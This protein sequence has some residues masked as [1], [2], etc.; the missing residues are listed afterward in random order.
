MRTRVTAKRL[1]QKTQ[2]KRGEKMTEYLII[3]NGVAGTTAAENI[4]KND[5]DGNITI[6]TD[7]DCPF[8]YRV[9]LNDYIAGE[10]TESA[11]KAKK[12]Q[13]Y[14]DLKINL[15]LK[16]RAVNVDPEKRIVVTDGGDSLIYDKLLFASGSYSFIPPMKGVE[17]KGVFAIRNI[18]DAR[19]IIA[20]AKEIREVVIIG[21]GLLGLE[22]GHALRKLNK[23][24]MV[25][26][27]FPRLLPRQ[28]DK[29]GA[30]RLQSIMEGMGFRFRL[31]TST[32]E[33]EGADTVNAVKLKDGEK[34]P[35]E[36]VI[37]SAGVRPHMGLA[38]TMGIECDK[39]IKV[40][41]YLRTSFPDI[42][43]AGDVVEFKGVSYGI[44]PAAMDQGKIAG[45][46]IAGGNIVYK[47]TTM[48]TTLKVVGID[49]ASAGDIDADNKHEARIS[50]SEKTYKKIVI[51]DNRLIGCIMLGDTF[52]F[53]KITRAITEKKDISGIK[54]KILSE[55]FD[56]DSI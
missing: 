53:N 1:D 11:L 19:R 4:R 35:A 47:G 51:D 14:K 22:A 15:R 23:S 34:L 29:E 41:E 50:T 24:L 7:E 26:E 25:V 48:S 2:I 3:G 27:F 17:K 18:Q 37:I 20:F 54:D 31:G 12:E 5:K 28:L 33:I 42:Y 38:K 36:I 30:S 43:A 40:D 13:W 39:G 45:T 8:Y 21:G 44:W 9:R 6:I 52:G 55:G 10:L 32:E 49:L 56:F 16:A 46:N